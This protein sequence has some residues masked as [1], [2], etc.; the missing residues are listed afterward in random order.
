MV[1]YG[2]LLD[3]LN[4]GLQAFAREAF[5]FPVA[6]ELP[7]QPFSERLTFARQNIPPP[8]ALLLS[9]DER[10][11]V[12]AF[13]SLT[14]NTIIITGRLLRPD[15]TV[16]LLNQTLA[17]TADRAANLLIFPG[18]EG[19]L[20]S[21]FVLSAAPTSLIGSCYVHVA[22]LR[23]SDNNSLLTGLLCQGYVTNSHAINWPGGDSQEPTDGAGLI[24]SISGTDPA[25]G[26]EISETVPTGARWRLLGIRSGMVADANVATRVAQLVMTDG[27]TTIMLVPPSA[28]Q[29]AGQTRTY[30]ATG[31][32]IYPAVSASQLG[33]TLPPYMLLPAGA[34]ISTVT[35]NLQVGDNWT[36]PQL[37]VEEWLDV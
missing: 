20:L 31:A 13:N 16:T 33:W 35:L 8:G 3:D 2:K 29:T 7:L 30:N 23:G 14:D 28:S 10:I 1:E 25:P 5:V 37:L 15:G 6:E 24:R 22:V 26:A 12:A 18:Y 19:A 36:T 27:A 21:L 17:L 11:F 32:P 4:V 9:S 34:I